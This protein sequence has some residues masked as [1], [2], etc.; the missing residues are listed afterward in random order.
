MVYEVVDQQ[1]VLVDPDGV[2]LVTLNEVATL[3]WE[4]LDGCR[5]TAEIAAALF[6]RFEGV[7]LARLEQDIT[8]FL[9]AI[10]TS[11]LVRTGA[12]GRD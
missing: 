6:D 10:A 9:T 11:G 12:D 5:G 8:D 3:V 1:A 4:S 7:T 2:D